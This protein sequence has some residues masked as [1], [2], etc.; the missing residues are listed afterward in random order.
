MFNGNKYTKKFES[1]YFGKKSRKKIK[2]YQCVEVINYFK[3][4]ILKAY[5][6]IKNWF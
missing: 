3:A 1:P 4:F 6:K 5:K 2:A